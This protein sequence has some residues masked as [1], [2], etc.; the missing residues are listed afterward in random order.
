MTVPEPDAT[1]YWDD[2]SRLHPLAA[3]LDPVAGAER[4][5]S[6]IDRMHRLALRRAMGGE[7]FE[8]ILDFGCGIGRMAPE[9]RQFSGRVT[10]I[11]ISPE[12]I[13]QAQRLNASPGIEFVTYDGQTLPFEDGS[14]DGL[15][16]VVV[17][18]LYR[19]HTDR[20][21]SIAGEFARVLRP[22]GRAWLIEQ[23]GPTDAS[24]VW[25]PERWRRELGTVGLEVMRLRPIRHFR[26]SLIF[27]ATV[28]GVVPSRLLQAATQ[29][30]LG[31]TARAGIRSPYT[32][33]LMSVVRS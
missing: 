29:L 4:K 16:S 20:F 24:D 10:G 23:A 14:F 28:T 1:D 12:M 2:R 17:L 15:L 3:V 22:G 21:R 33:C 5:N 25:P 6:Q 19:D 9:L 32:E 30:D 27:R 8:H 11:D 18:Q 13:A 26:N 31:F 7:R